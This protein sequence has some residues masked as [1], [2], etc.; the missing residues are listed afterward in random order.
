MP[1]AG[2]PKAATAASEVPMAGA[3]KAAVT[4]SV[5]LRALKARASAWRSALFGKA[6]HS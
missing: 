6:R 3:P 5:A 4:A 2:A 1:M